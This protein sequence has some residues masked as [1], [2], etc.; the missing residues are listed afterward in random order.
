MAKKP[1]TKQACLSEFA[2][3]YVNAIVE[4][5]YETTVSQVI[6]M[7]IEDAATESG[8]QDDNRAQSNREEGA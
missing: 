7:I 8:F 3:S 2:M 5:S 1:H 4:D 6:N